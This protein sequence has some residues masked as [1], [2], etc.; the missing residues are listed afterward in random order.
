MPHVHWIS[1][2]VR[3]L[4]DPAAA[5]YVQMFL[6]GQI[7]EHKLLLLAPHGDSHPIL[8]QLS[9]ASVAGRRDNPIRGMASESKGQSVLSAHIRTISGYNKLV[10]SEGRHC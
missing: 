9:D 4:C 8:I 3:Q 6:N 10:G 1:T 2:C 7:F 5:K